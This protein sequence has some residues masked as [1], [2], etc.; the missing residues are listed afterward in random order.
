MESGQAGALSG[1]RVIELAAMGP[2]PFCGMLLGDMGADV[3]RID[4]VGGSDLGVEMRPEHDLRGRGKRSIAIDVKLPVGREA[5]LSLAAGADIVMEGFRPGVV[6]RLGIGPKECMAARPSLVYGR[7]T[8]WGQDGPLAETSGH[9]INYIAVAGALGLIGPEGGAPVPPLNLVGDYGGGA[10]Y[11][12]L[13]LL[14]AVIRARVSGRGQVVDAAMIDGVNSLLTVFHGFQQHGQ[15]L[16]PRGAN[17]LDGGA[18]YYACY[19]TSDGG[20]MAAGPIEPRF[21][22]R[23]IERLGL[24]PAALPD[25]DD[26]ARWPELRARLAARFLTRTRAEWTEIFAGSDACVTPVL[27]LEEARMHPHN[28]ARGTMVTVDGVLHPRPAPRLSETPSAIR[29]PPPRP[30]Q[31]TREILAEC[32]FDAAR[33]EEGLRS[34]AFHAP[35]ARKGSD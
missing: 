17:I 19:R 6:E 20:Y 27:S 15:H 8:G 4:R 14:A 13:G 7:A 30:G 2:V 5:F 18:P 31:H 24:D 34:G 35:D 25:Q 1:I 12:A 16:D 21:H 3:I 22:A 11:L 32:G 26:R 33:I 9:D 28:A 10:L 29:R 23:M